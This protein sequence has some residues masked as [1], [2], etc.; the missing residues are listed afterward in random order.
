[1]LQWL[2]E[3]ITNIAVAV[4]FITAIEMLL[5]KNN[6]KKYGKFVL[7]L[8][9]I[10]VILNPIIKIFN[11]DYNISQ[12]VEKATASFNNVD[13]KNDFDKYKKKNREETLN[14]FKANLQNQTKKRLEEKFPEN[15]YEVN[16]EIAYDEEK[17]NLEIKSMDVGVKGNKIEKIKKVN[18]INIGSNENG[19]E[20]KK[21]FEGEG[22]IK[23]FIS[24]EFKVSSE[25]IKVYKL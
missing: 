7:G 13:Y 24:N 15:K 25:V 3:W 17:D 1:M 14:N 22:K 19:K 23:Q 4:F 16:V 5:P 9:L 18:K 10:T 2:K 12:Y 6:I 8:I 21:S 11:K 20:D